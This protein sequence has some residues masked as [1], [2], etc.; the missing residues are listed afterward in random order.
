MD[1]ITPP[2]EL[3]EWVLAERVPGVRRIAAPWIHTDSAYT[4]LF[5]QAMLQPW[6]SGAGTVFEASA[7]H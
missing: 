2:N 5:V 1:T 4:I 7:Y 3:H 6:L